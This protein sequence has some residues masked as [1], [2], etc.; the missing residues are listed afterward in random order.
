MKRD[1]VTDR[2]MTALRFLLIGAVTLPLF[3]SC[4][5]DQLLKSGAPG[6]EPPPPPDPAVSPAQPEGVGQFR[7][8]GTTPVRAGETIDETSIVIAATLR[9][10]QPEDVLRLQLELRPLGA[11]FTGAVT[12]T[13]EIVA[14]GDR[15]SVTISVAEIDTAYAW[16]V[17]TVDNGGHVSAWLRFGTGSAFRVAVPRLP[18]M[19]VDLAQYESNGST[20]IPVGGTVDE[21]DV[22]LR[23][24]APQTASTAKVRMEFEVRSSTA[25]FSGEATHQD[26]E[27]EPGTIGSVKFRAAAFTGY[28][29]RARVCGGAGCSAWVDFGGNAIAERDFYRDPFEDDDDG[30]GISAEPRRQ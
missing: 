20:P 9:D 23:A 26:D 25:A 3:A 4:S 18:P 19:P 15:A 17:R 1:T 22:F 12:H 8:D 2:A 6:S 29:W 13:S 16:Q 28:H 5:V 7:A 14:N 11:A 10:P 27:V 24:R 21:R 30:L